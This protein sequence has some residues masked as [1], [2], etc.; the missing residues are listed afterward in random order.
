ML[1]L[2]CVILGASVAQAVHVGDHVKVQAAVH[3]ASEHGKAPTGLT[4]NDKAIA[5][6]SS[7]AVASQEDTL[8]AVDTIKVDKAQDGTS[9]EFGPTVQGH[10]VPWHAIIMIVGLAWLH[11]FVYRRDSVGP[12]IALV[13]VVYISLHTASST[14]Q[15][16]VGKVAKDPV[17]TA[18]AIVFAALLV[19]LSV[20]S[21]LV[22]IECAQ[23]DIG[24][25][26]LAELM[27]SALICIFL[28]SMLYTSSDLLLV[29]CQQNMSMTEV[30][31]ISKI[32][33]PITVVFWYVIF[34]VGIGYQKMFGL[35]IIMCGTG[36]YAYAQQQSKASSAAPRPAP[37]MEGIPSVWVFRLFMLCQA[38]LATLGGVSNEY[39]LLKCEATTNM[40]NTAMYT[41]GMIFVICQALAL[42]NPIPYMAMINF[43]RLEW[44]LACFL[45]MTGICTSHFLKHL[46]SI[47]KQ[48][49][50]GVMLVAFFAVDTL[51]LGHTYGTN[52][53]MGVLVVAVGICFYVIA[54]VSEDSRLQSV[55]SE[56]ELQKLEEKKQQKKGS[57]TDQAI[58]LK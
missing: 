10:E 39:M 4:P 15:V 56:E 50:Y 1:S 13:Y 23:Q 46:G 18:Q 51:Y 52:V 2:L 31:I 11:F 25:K 48:V 45:S 12:G 42:G 17:G 21:V 7:E 43:T 6:V 32:A 29:F 5:A 38:V 33:I 8:Q 9:T 47:W 28:P 54:G 37:G 20:S 49:A 24:F 53:I 22:G 40:L 35:I 16:L 41:E 27:K 58:K 57:D 14:T 55:L 26:K 34:R 44:T 3:G 36:L 19:K 30:Q